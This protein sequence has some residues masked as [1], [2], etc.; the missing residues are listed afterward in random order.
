MKRIS[1][2][3]ALLLIILCSCCKEVKPLRLMSFN[4]E[5]TSGTFEKDSTT[6][7][8]ARHEPVIAML[9]D[10]Q[11]DVAFFQESQKA[12]VED[13]EKDLADSYSLVKYD[14]KGGEYY[15]MSFIYRK[16]RIELIECEPRWFSPN[17]SIPFTS[18]EWDPKFT[19]MAVLATFRDKATGKEFYMAGAHFFPSND[20]KILCSKLMAQWAEEKAGDRKP[21]VACGDMNLTP[22][23]AGLQ[24]LYDIMEDSV[25]AA[26]IS[27]GRE[28]VTF[29][30]WGKGKGK[31]LDHIFFR[32]LEPLEYHVVDDCEKYGLKYLSDHNAI[33]CD[34]LFTE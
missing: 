23:D 10:V 6:S 4:I 5:H 29:Q 22:D 28:R 8:E 31:V 3:T 27:D 25:D 7:W 24:P 32:G 11:P 17:P 26:K 20:K 9:R 19:K 13:M 21:A 18:G 15:Y 34:F 33:Y 14:Q 2:A 12:H 16:D 1:A 30:R